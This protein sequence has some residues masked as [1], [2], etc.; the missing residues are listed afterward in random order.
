[1]SEM[2]YFLLAMFLIVLVMGLYLRS[3]LITVFTF[4]DVIFSFALAYFMY[5]VVFQIPHMPF[6]AFLTIL[7]LIA[8]AADN[9]F[10]F[11]D[12]FERIKLEHPGADLEFWMSK[13][14]HHAAISILVTSL[15]TSAALFANIV[16]EITDIHAFGII[17]GTALVMNY[18]LVVTW[19]PCGIIAIEKFDQKYLSNIKCCDCFGRLTKNVGNLSEKIFHKIIPKLVS[20]AWFIWMVIF[21]GLGIS[22]IVVTYISPKL[23]LPDSKDFAL[24]HEE[25]IIE[26]WF[27]DLKYEFRY[28]H[29]SGRSV[30]G[31]V[32]STMFGIKGEDTGNLLDPDSIGDLEFDPSF[33]LSQPEAQDW[34]LK[35][36]HN[37]K[38]ASIVDKGAVNERPCTLD[39][40][41]SYVTKS[42]PAL[43]RDLLSIYG[44]ETFASL[45]FTGCCGYD[46]PRI[47]PEA[48]SRCFYN[49]NPVIAMNYPKGALLGVPY[50]DIKTHD[51]KAYR[52][53]FTTKDHWSGDY[54]YMDP[55]NKQLQD[56]MSAQLSSAPSSLN[57][58]WLAAYYDAFEL[59]DLQ[60]ALASGT[61]SAIAVSMA[62]AFIVMLITSRNVLI[63]VYAIFTIFLTI[64]VTSGTLVLLGWKLN[65]VESVTLTL[66][67]GL[68]IDFCIHYGM[69][70]RLS[71]R[72][73]RRPRV[74]ESFE[75][76]G[77]A[78]F[79]AAATTFIA[80]LCMMPATVLFYIQLGTFLMLVMTISWLFSTFFFQ[81][82]CYVLGPRGNFCQY[83]SPL[84][85]CKKDKSCSE[86]CCVSEPKD[87]FSLLMACTTEN[88]SSEDVRRDDMNSQNE[89]PRAH[90]YDGSSR[91][92][93]GAR[94]EVDIHVDIHAYTGKPTSRTSK[95][96]P[97]YRSSAHVTLALAPDCNGPSHLAQGGPTDSNG[98]SH[99]PAGVEHRNDSGSEGGP[100]ICNGTSNIALGGP[101]ETQ[102]FK[103]ETGSVDPETQPLK[104]ETDV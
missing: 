42:C 82:L 23:Q 12:T 9:V 7:L 43:K 88:S 13:T 92:T 41:Y 91:V 100:P 11:C 35:F 79:M 31:I 77:A 87:I 15:T 20:K 5:F 89:R 96:L 86:F 16:S 47:P 61:Y 67:V 40:F 97:V 6:M 36:C 28:T 30:G 51:L 38:N 102:P 17:A 32:M 10:V 1:M 53:D 48:F 84:I 29:V 72:G 101:P 24:F 62:A 78:I 26:K 49:L 19:I 85:L 80:G 56:W 25:T 2:K 104:S 66:A 73:D 37:L 69:G 3:A 63:T 99:L 68:S 33:D 90:Y 8:I 93:M 75:K 4:L 14:M 27:M 58:G 74:Q 94:D 81:S 22:G 95:N 52:L 60:R 18:L 21:V 103:S 59:Y 44:Y 71:E 46:S 76:V 45:N 50:F 39:V 83:P 70:Y 98:P 64:S 34:M 57:D 65:V 55:L 54:A